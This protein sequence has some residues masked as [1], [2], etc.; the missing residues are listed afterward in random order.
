MAVEAP[1]PGIEENVFTRTL[2]RMA[3]FYSKESQH[4][5]GAK[6]LYSDVVEQATNKSLLDG[7]TQE[8]P[9]C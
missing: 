6:A 5:R 1:A 9:S 8:P 2:L 3:G 7:T 4:I